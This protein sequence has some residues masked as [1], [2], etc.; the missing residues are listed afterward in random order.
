V[1]V[2]TLIHLACKAHAL[3]SIVIFSQHGFTIFFHIN[4]LMAG[5]S[6]RKITEQKTCLM[7]FFAQTS[8]SKKHS[9]RYSIYVCVCVCIKL[10]SFH[11][12]HL[13]FSSYLNHNSLLPTDFLEILKY[14]IPLKSFQWKP[15]CYMRTDGQTD[16][17]TGRTKLV[18][19]IRSFAKAFKT[20]RNEMITIRSHTQSE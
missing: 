11:L 3:Y 6:K 8:H 17:R 5:F 7:H 15:S 9:A 18:A 10:Q 2:C 16:K 13:L 12:K 14:Q 1:G 20:D 19:A 4:S